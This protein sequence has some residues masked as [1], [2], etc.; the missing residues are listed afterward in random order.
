MTQHPLSPELDLAATRGGWEGSCSPPRMLPE[1]FALLSFPISF[2]ACFSGSSTVLAVLS[3]DSTL[4]LLS[5]TTGSPEFCCSP[6]SSLPFSGSLFSGS[7]ASGTIVVSGD[8]DS[9][10]ILLLLN[11]EACFFHRPIFSLRRTA[12]AKSKAIGVIAPSSSS[13]VSSTVLIDSMAPISNHSSWQICSIVNLF[14]G[15]FSIIFRRTSAISGLTVSGIDN[16]LLVM[17]SNTL[18][19]LSPQ[20]GKLPHTK[21]Y[22]QTPNAHTSI[23]NPLYLDSLIIS[24]AIN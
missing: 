9:S 12:A 7:E 11:E 3:T 13:S 10:S 23:K 8:V 4:T 17:T 18:S 21:M 14:L 1:S 5:E 16:G 2:W 22:K 6:F 15:S 19:A 20:K 24:G